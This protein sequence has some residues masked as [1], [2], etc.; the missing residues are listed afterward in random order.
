MTDDSNNLISKDVMLNMIESHKT[1]TEYNTKLYLRQ[2]ALVKEQ[3]KA[4]ENLLQ[5]VEKQKEI[6]NQLASLITTMSSHNTIMRT[7]VD[8]LKKDIKSDH[9]NNVKEHGKIKNH[10]IGLTGGMIVVVIGLLSALGSMWSKVDIIDAVA[11]HL[12]LQ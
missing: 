2:E 6:N 11:K 10:L 1:N 9:I 12:G 7:S 3:T 5:I 8:D 4:T